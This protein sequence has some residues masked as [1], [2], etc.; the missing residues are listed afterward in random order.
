[1]FWFAVLFLV[2]VLPALINGFPLYQNDSGSYSGAHAIATGIRSVMPGLLAK[3]L[4]PLL[5]SWAL[6]FVN[7]AF[8]SLVVVRFSTVALPHVPMGLVVLGVFA[9]G[10]PF[11]SSS[12]MPDMWISLAYLTLL[13]LLIRFSWIDF[14]LCV[15]A[16]MGHGLNPYIFAS[17][18]ILAILFLRG[19]RGRAAKLIVTILF[20]SI[21]LEGGISYLGRGE[22]FP[23]KIGAAVVA[24]KVINDV[25]EAYD[26]FCDR[27]A[28][29][30]ICRLRTK[31]DARRSL[32]VDKFDQYL[33]D[34]DLLSRQGPQDDTLTWNEFNA[35]GIKLG[36]FVLRNYPVEYVKKSLSEFPRM[37]RGNGCL[38][39]GSGYGNIL[40]EA[41]REVGVLN[42]DDVRSLARRGVYEGATLC[43]VLSWLRFVTY[44]SA[45]VA[46][47]YILVFRSGALRFQVLVLFAA[48][49][50]NDTGYLFTSG[51]VPRYHDRILLLAATI[52][53]LLINHLS[54]RRKHD[55]I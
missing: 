34:A 8:V 22:L 31:V 42:T 6:A 50:V 55:K 5:G 49:W 21:L 38:S 19:S 12:I 14:T 1:M 2:G 13:L 7:A 9:A 25:P 23:A 41:W 33:W 45:M 37:F 36:L 53:L 29:E 17:T 39:E 46:A 44:I 27:F 24:S 54:G 43:S 52:V 51:W 35:A 16:V 10:T 11:F 40:P 28:E 26:R 20:S 15:I 47:L 32:R 48:I 4:F 18:L 3:P 30:K